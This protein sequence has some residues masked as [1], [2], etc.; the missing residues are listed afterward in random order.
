MMNSVT[1]C[2][3]SIFCIRAGCDAAEIRIPGG[4]SVGHTEILNWLCYLAVISI[5]SFLLGRLLPY[6]WFHPDRFPYRT[7]KW[8]RGGKFYQRIGLPKWQN[9]LPDMSKLL[10]RLMPAKAMT[11]R[12][13]E[14]VG[15]MITETCIAELVHLMLMVLAFGALH[16]WNGPLGVVL[17]VLYCLG[18]LP[19][20]LI[21]RYNR[22]RLI[23]LRAMTEKREARKKAQ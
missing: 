13:A 11:D 14:A 5:G 9:R 3:C 23:R 15:V 20:V 18:N 6:G 1:C 2:A 22:P 19:F 4:Y 10:P 7:W 8:E 17:T 16:F 12:S 21:Q